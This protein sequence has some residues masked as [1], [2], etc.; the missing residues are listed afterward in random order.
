M[1]R[2]LLALT[3]VYFIHTIYCWANIKLEDFEVGYYDEALTEKDELYEYSLDI[4]RMKVVHAFS[5][6]GL[7]IY[8]VLVS[9]SYRV[10]TIRHYYQLLA[11]SIIMTTFFVLPAVYLFYVMYQDHKQATKEGKDGI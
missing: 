5:L 7:S 10:L 6:L 2:Y 11:V 4:E 9:A 8:I 1:S 3:G